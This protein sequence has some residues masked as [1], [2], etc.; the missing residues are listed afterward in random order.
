MEISGRQQIVTSVWWQL[1]SKTRKCLRCQGDL[2]NTTE[3][4]I[5]ETSRCDF[6]LRANQVLTQHSIIQQPVHL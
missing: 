6:I 2:V 5:N 4:T 1:D 3:M